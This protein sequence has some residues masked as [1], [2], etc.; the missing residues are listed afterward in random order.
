[1]SEQDLDDKQK[2]DQ[3][4]SDIDWVMSTEQGRRF[5][6][7]MLSECGLYHDFEGDANTMFKQAGRRQI[8]LF[9]LGIIPQDSMFQMMKDAQ[10]KEIEEKL[11][12]DN[13]NK[14]DTSIG[15]TSSDYDFIGGYDSGGDGPNF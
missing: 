5:V 15:D 10:N 3:E 8:A 9:L 2:L 13:R 6:W 12:H 11:K 14:R 1:M 4:R 7:R